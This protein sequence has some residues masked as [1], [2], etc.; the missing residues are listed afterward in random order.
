MSTSASVRN[1]GSV[2]H[3]FDHEYAAIP[4]AIGLVRTELRQRLAVEAGIP[5]DKADDALLITHELV[6]NVVRHSRAYRMRVTLTIIDAAG[7]LVGIV[8]DDGAGTVAL[9]GP[10][11]PEQADLL[12]ESGTGLGIV[13]AL[14]DTCSVAY[15]RHGKTIT[16]ALRLDAAPSDAKSA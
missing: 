11:D 2:R 15:D 4:P 14:A 1:Q 13:S 6:A 9:P 5:A 8:Q 10:E 12:K 7:V 3:V 16:W